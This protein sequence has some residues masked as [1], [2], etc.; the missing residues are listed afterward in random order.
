MIFNNILTRMKDTLMKALPNC[1]S[2][3]I[4]SYLLPNKED[5]TF[6]KYKPGRNLDYYSERYEKALLNG[7]LC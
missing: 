7:K 1:I 2:K 5:I 4:F 6:I 3:E